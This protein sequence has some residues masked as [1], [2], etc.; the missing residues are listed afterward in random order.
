MF[1]FSPFRL[2]CSLLL[3]F[4]AALVASAQPSATLT[5]NAG[6]YEPAGGTLTFTSTL[7]YTGL[8]PSVY[9]FSVQLP[10]GWK[11][12]SQ[13]LGA[14]L[15]A[16]ASPI[17]NDNLL[18]WAFSAFPANQA[19]WSFVVTY[20]AGTSGAQTVSVVTAQYRSPITNLI[21]PAI[22]FT[23]A[24]PSAPSITS[25]P[26]SR[27]V[28]AGESVSFSV[29]ASGTAP[30]TY[31]W[32]KDGA[33]ISGA[34]NASYSISS[35]QSGHAGAYSVVVSNSVGSMTSNAATLTV[36]PPSPLPR[37][38][39]HPQSRTVDVGASVTFTVSAGGTGLSY[40]WKKD[41]VAIV[42]ATSASFTIASARTSDAGVYT[43]T[44]WNND[45]SVTSN[46][47]TL[48][49]NRTGGNAS[50]LAAIATRAYCTGGN[51]VAIGGFVISGNN[52]K[53]VLMRA[54]GPTLVTQGIP[55]NEVLADPSFTLH[56]VALKNE[57][58]ASSDNWG[59]NANAASIVSAAARLGAFP[60]AS[61]DTTSAALLMVLDPGA[62]TFVVSGKNNTSGIVLIEVYDAD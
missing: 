37:I 24:V 14:G 39:G 9:A 52:S 40:Q 21:V 44:V 18:E 61:T 12:V 25:H 42:G 60:L 2:A 15:T 6:T 11:L 56:S 20:P 8:T 32:R 43:V 47:A 46:G 27:A 28:T 62:Y 54:V 26:Q 50:T 34:T 16:S 31:Q 10:T 58:I 7:T 22:T 19:S 48:T 53:Q 13:S 45:G 55:Q 41:E 3:F 57:V 5:A 4:A 29:S 59:Q 23:A 30:L 17:A 35:A 38:T 49:V 33:P 51:G 1:K 36:N